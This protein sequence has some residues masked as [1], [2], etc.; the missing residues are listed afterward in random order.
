VIGMPIPPRAICGHAG[1]LRPLAA[2]LQ[3][4]FAGPRR[5]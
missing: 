1:K 2:I 4:V 5:M 3:A